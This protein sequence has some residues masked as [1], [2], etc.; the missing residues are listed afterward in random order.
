MSE[1]VDG[2]QGREREVVLY[3]VTAHYEHE[4]LLDY[5]RANVAFSRAR[6]KLIVFS[7]LRSTGKTPWLKYL[8]LRAHRVTINVTELEPERALYHLSR[9]NASYPTKYLIQQLIFEHRYG[10]SKSLAGD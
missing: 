1:T 4:A 7:S 5:R 6:S 10:N 3:S 8:R 9:D 2:Y